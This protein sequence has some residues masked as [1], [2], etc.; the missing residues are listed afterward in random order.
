[1]LS[2]DDVGPGLLRGDGACGCVL[3]DAGIFGCGRIAHVDEVV[4]VLRLYSLVAAALP[5]APRDVR[6]RLQA[7]VPA[8][9]HEHDEQTQ[10][11]ADDRGP[12]VRAQPEVHLAGIDADRLPDDAAGAV[13]HE[14][15]TEKATPLEQEP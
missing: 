12:H 14:V 8:L 3:T 15:E 7:R 11:D 13:P 4:G 5:F 9:L 1:M 10:D 2:W 6:R